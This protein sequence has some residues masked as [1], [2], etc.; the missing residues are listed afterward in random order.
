MSQS[1]FDRRVRHWRTQRR[2]TSGCIVRLSDGRTTIC[3]CAEAS[4]IGCR[5]RINAAPKNFATG[6]VEDMRQAVMAAP[7]E[8]LPDLSAALWRAFA[9][10]A[11]TEADAEALSLAIE[12]RK[13]AG[14]TQRPA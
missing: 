14:A 6:P 8:R 7:R 13:A 11:V 10:G 1:F 3:G 12:A 4:P 5:S 9:A 2:L